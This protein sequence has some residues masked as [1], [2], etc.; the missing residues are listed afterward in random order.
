L[1]GAAAGAS[2]GNDNFFYK[3]SKQPH[4]DAEGGTQDAAANFQVGKAGYGQTVMPGETWY[5]AVKME[6]GNTGGKFVG[7]LAVNAPN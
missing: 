3:W 5:V 1:T 6:G 2:G 4:A 7:E